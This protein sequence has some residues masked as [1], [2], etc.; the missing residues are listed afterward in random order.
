MKNIRPHALHGTVK[1]EKQIG[2]SFSVFSNLHHVSS[3]GTVKVFLVYQV[4]NRP[5]KYWFS[6]IS[7][8]KNDNFERVN[9]NTATEIFQSRTLV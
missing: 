9:K 1:C 2:A 6:K 5:N 8:F 3:I 4:E 7:L